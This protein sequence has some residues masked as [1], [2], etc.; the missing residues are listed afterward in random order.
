MQEHDKAPA[1]DRAVQTRTAARHIAV[2][3]KSADGHF[4]GDPIIPGAVLLRE[5]IAAVAGDSDVVEI[6]SAKFHHPV[7]PGVTLIV[8]WTERHDGEVRFSCSTE[9]SDRPV[10]TGNLRLALA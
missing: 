5:I 2:G 4:P 1:T 7:R 9:G 10:V 8:S 3:D 6:R